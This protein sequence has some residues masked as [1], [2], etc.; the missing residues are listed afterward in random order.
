MGEVGKV[1]TIVTELKSKGAIQAIQSNNN[2][3][4]AGANNVNPLGAS[5]LMQMLR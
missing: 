2:P 3:A 1:H 4:G 5:T